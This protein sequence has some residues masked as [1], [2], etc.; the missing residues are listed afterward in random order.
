MN[1]LE[2]YGLQ[3]EIHRWA[4][5]KGW[6]Q[7]AVESPT[8]I[9]AKLMLCVSELVEA[10]EELRNNHSPRETYTH[11][12]K[13]EGFAIELADAVIR[14]LDLAEFCGVDVEQAIRVKMG[15]NETREYKHGGKAF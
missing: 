4:L 13:P 10:M 7:G 2:L 1:H 15:Y 5:K 9:G 6:W 8:I 3:V 12:G 11:E 14:I